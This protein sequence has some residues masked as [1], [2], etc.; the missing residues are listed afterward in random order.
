MLLCLLLAAV[1]QTSPASPPYS[2]SHVNGDGTIEM[3][4]RAQRLV[5]PGKPDVWLIGAVHVGTS[6][7]YS[8]LQ[9]LL[10]SQEMVLYEGVKPAGA[11]DVP[12]KPDPKAPRPV[13]KVLSD[14]IGLDF[15]LSDIDYNHPN[16][17]DVDLTW[18]QMMALNKKA[19][20]GKPNQVDTI[21]NL[22]NPQSQGSK[23]LASMLG[24]ATPGTKEALKIIM[25]KVVASGMGPGLDPNTTN[26]IV[27]ARNQVVLKKLASV[28]N[29]AN[30]PKSVG[31]FYG[32]MHLPG[33]EK[34][35]AAS[36][37][38]KEADQKWFTSATADPKKLDATGKA[39]LALFNSK[40]TSPTMPKSPKKD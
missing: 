25:V 6:K 34:A 38:Y 3:Q 39:L 9:T 40:P 22:L 20:N 1:A 4:T 29:G 26:I 5:A 27:G 8:M 35:L 2:Q 7:Y 31:I 15:Q 18:D 32:A 10:D 28:V 30:Q 14:A 12:M 36:Y 16:W 17:S 23:T 33:I 37:G 21:A 13:Y 24:A 19:S 11:E